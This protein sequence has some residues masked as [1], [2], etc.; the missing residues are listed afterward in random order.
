LDY[1]D[2]MAQDNR[3]IALCIVVDGAIK[4]GAVIIPS[5]TLLHR[6]TSS[7]GSSAAGSRMSW[8]RPRKIGKRDYIAGIFRDDCQAYLGIGIGCSR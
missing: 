1:V 8:P 4:L 6:K 3:R 2:P 5:R 7:T